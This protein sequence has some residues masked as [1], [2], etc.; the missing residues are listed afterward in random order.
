MPAILIN[1]QPTEQLSVLDRGFQYGDGLFETLR[2]SAGRPRRWARH[3]AR[4]AEGCQRLGIG[5]PEPALLLS[6]ATSLCAAKADAV[7]KIIVT[8]GVGERG[9]APPVHAEATRVLSVSP[10][11]TFPQAYYHDGVCVRAC[12]TRLG[13]NPALAGIKH[14]NRLEQ[15]LA[16]AEWN[17]ERNQERNQVS[18]GEQGETDI[19]EGLMLDTATKNNNVIEGTMSNLFCVQASEAGP[20]LKTPLLDQCGVKGITRQCIME[21]AETA[22]IPVQEVTLGLDELYRSEEL[23]LCNTLIGI[24][25]V[26]K[27]ED[28]AFAVGP[29]TRQLS[30]MLESL[31][32]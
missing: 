18:N 5:M 24:W 1:G 2:I 3:M 16:R 15:V 6:E 19:A 25:P 28:Q 13:R 29:V 8:R 9:Y 20:V 31:H 12:H 22:R 7:L 10:M 11:P 27:L 21:M 23:F 17:Q 32:D 14:L 26:R 30:Q 4:L